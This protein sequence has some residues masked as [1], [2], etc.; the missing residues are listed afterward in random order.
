MTGRGMDLCKVLH[1]SYL[2]LESFQL[3]CRVGLI[4]FNALAGEYVAS[5]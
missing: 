2:A 3:L 5:E 4:L 1:T